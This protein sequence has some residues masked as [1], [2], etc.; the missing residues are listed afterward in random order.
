VPVHL[1]NTEVLRDVPLILVPNPNYLP[2][3]KATLSSMGL[4]PTLVTV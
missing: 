4:N 3:I 2:E 1:P